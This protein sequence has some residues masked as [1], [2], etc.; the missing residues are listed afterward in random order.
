MDSRKKIKYMNVTVLMPEYL[1]AKALGDWRAARQSC[2]ETKHFA[3]EDGVEWE[4]IH[5]RF[6]G[7]GGFVLDFSGLLKDP[8]D[9]PLT[10]ETIPADLD[11][12]T[13]I[14]ASRMTHRMWALNAR[15]LRY[16]RQKGLIRNLP[17]VSVREL[18]QLRKDDSL[19]KFLTIVQVTW[20]IIQLITRQRENLPSSQLEI[21][22]LAFSAASLFTFTLLW[23]R[24]QG[25]QRVHRIIATRLPKSQEL[26][27]LECMGPR[28]GI[29][30]QSRR[31]GDMD[32]IPI[33]NN[34]P[35]RACNHKI[36]FSTNSI[37]HHEVFCF[38]LG[39][40]FGGTLFGGFHCLAWKF[41]FPT[42]VELQLWRICSVMMTVLPVLGLSSNILY[43]KCVNDSH[44]LAE[45]VST[46]FLG[47]CRR[48]I[49]IGAFIHPCGTL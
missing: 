33:P 9:L 37:K 21:G 22:T 15:Q 1:M 44:I 29:R 8:L 42:S 6:A 4:P 2:R 49:C 46:T 48:S 27:D 45:G 17:T 47:V 13:R 26:S 10:E 11:P 40:S 20:L 14:T 43:L 34:A 31:H 39:L 41:H 25:V 35:A 30:T 24:P 38:L 5:A 18:E 7:M 28:T 12:H 36:V 16:A 19:A 32:L 3:D 23:G